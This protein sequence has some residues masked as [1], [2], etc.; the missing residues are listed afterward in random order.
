[1]TG[2]EPA[3]AA[4]SDDQRDEAFVAYLEAAAPRLQE[5]A[6]EPGSWEEVMERGFDLGLDKDDILE[7]AAEV[8]HGSPVARRKR[9]CCPACGHEIRGGAIP[10]NCPRCLLLLPRCPA[11]RMVNHALS[12]THCTNP[13]C[14]GQGARL[15]AQES[16]DTFRGNAARTGSVRSTA[17]AS[18]PSLSWNHDLGEPV[19]ASPIV[20]QGIV[21]VAGKEGLVAAFDRAGRPFSPP[22]SE[23]PVRVPD[24]VASTPLYHRGAVYVATLAGRVIALDAPSGRRVAEAADLGPIDASPAVDPAGGTVVVATHHGGLIGLDRETLAVRWRFPGKGDRPLGA[25][26]RASP[27]VGEGALVAVTE[28]GEIVA[29]DVTGS[30]ARERWRAWAPGEVLGT[31]VILKGFVCVLTKSGELAT[32]R[33]G[34]GRLNGKGASQ[35]ASFVVSSP[36][37]APFGGDGLL[38]GGADGML[39]AF[40]YLAARVQEGFP[41]NPEFPTPEPF[42]ASPAVAGDIA[43]L[44]DDAGHLLGFDVARREP[45]WKMALGSP[46]RSSPALDGERLYVCTES[47]TLYCFAAAAE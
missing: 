10:D 6:R 41:V 4:L 37:L 9:R 3:G 23:W 16:W 26:F 34:D 46:V 20:G 19:V 31:P 15:A 25:A 33:L 44:A 7:I 17:A 43:I 24:S 32:Y 36:A 42:L 5:G 28:A 38:F 21:F 14:K 8:L 45:V 39:H 2:V 12:A 27:A 40:D 35:G 11:C 1:M 29:L 30:H 47:G 18:L 13:R 22:G